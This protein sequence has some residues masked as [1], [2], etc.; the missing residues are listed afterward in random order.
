M[1][2]GAQLPDEDTP[3]PEHKLS[4]GEVYI[5]LIE[6]GNA[7]KFSRKAQ[8]MSIRS[9]MDDVITVL[10]RDYVTVLDKYLRD[11]FLT[12][13]NKY[14]ALKDGAEGVNTAA[15]TGMF[16]GDTLQSLVEKAQTLN[17]PKISRGA[18]DFFVFIGTPRQIRQMRNDGRWLNARQYTD[19]S[20]MF[21]GEA[22]RLDDVVFLQTTHMPTLAGAGSGGEDVS[23]GILIGDNAVGYAESIPMELIPGQVEDY[24]RRMSMAWYMIGG[25]GILNDYLIECQTADILKYS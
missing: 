12:T 2:E 8:S 9:L 23:R 24:G 7:S 22:G 10:G 5:T 18:D 6:F 17:F 13:A 15:V 3:I 20:D 16:D 21:T 4:T 25:A 19:P 1:P 14:Y 11:V